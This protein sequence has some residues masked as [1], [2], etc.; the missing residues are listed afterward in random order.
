M[1][2][3]K[4]RASGIA[5]IMGDGKGA[6]GL[7][8]TAKTYLN[9][10]AKE[11]AYGFHEKI[12]T[13]YFRKGIQCEAEGIEL[14]NNVMFTK[15]EKNTARID[16]EWITGEC[17]ILVPKVKV[18]DVKAAWSLATFPATSDEVAATSK[19]S[20]YDFQ[21][22]AYMWLYDVDLSE[23]VYY[24]VSTPEELRKYEQPEI[25]EVDHIHPSLRITVCQ[26][27][28]DAAIEA[29]MKSK[30]IAAR[31]YLENYAAQIRLDHQH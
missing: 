31:N 26:F 8:V 17:D 10:I 11:F 21:L 29:K 15:Y 27:K 2:D 6:D 30:V 4:F 9:G 16:N 18:I 23:V 7:S 12:D 3:F 14:L 13:K 19:K 5:E 28:R 24:M 20:G 1:N 25:H 22:A